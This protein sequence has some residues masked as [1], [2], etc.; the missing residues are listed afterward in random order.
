MAGF[1]DI[2]ASNAVTWT[3]GALSQTTWFRR[4]AR[5]DCMA[6]WTGAAESNA[7][8]ITVN[9]WI[10]A[11]ISIVA[12]ANPVC[13]G[14]L[15][16]FT[17]TPVNPGSSPVFEWKINGSIAGTSNPVFSYPPVDADVVQCYLTSSLNCITL[18]PVP[19][20]QLV[21][22]TLPVPVVSFDACFDTITTIQA[23]PFKLKGGLPLGGTYSG[24][25][26]NSLTG[27]FNPSS[28]GVGTK[29]LLYTYANSSLCTAAKS[30]SVIIHPAPVFICNSPVTD[31]RDQ[32]VYATVMIG[33]QCWMAEN[34]DHGQRINGTIAQRDNC[35]T[36]K[37]CL[38]DMAVNCIQ[39]GALYQWDEIMRY[40][41]VPGQQGLCPPGWHIP[42]ANDWNVL[43]S[44]WFSSGFAGSPLKY[45]GYSGFNA[46]L[47]G[48][49]VANRPWDFAGFA[50]F[51]WSS[52]P[53][54][55]GKAWA[56]GMNDYNPSVST[57]P[58][59]KS[60]AFSVRCIRD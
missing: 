8:E 26:V 13:P 25:G 31:I 35:F 28:A 47:A 32:K 14:T 52:T 60:N 15:V 34:L 16:T 56:H 37:Y 49:D 22:N 40:E 24:S 27:I 23:K 11:G 59:L 50:T 33:T 43:F 57:Y 4:L 51:F 18:N 53:Y 36:E 48:V 38:N 6:D 9:P 41:D 2:P 20:N 45:S 12:S 46:L 17:A 58:S 55:S 44:N 39:L 7:I 54:I 29:T 5:V 42:T 10:T 30:R 19:S 21:I 1:T 3:P